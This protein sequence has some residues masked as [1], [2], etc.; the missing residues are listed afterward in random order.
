M[1]RPAE[2]QIPIQNGIMFGSNPRALSHD[3]ESPL[4]YYNT[5]W[6]VNDAALYIIIILYCLTNYDKGKMCTYLAQ[7]NF[8]LKYFQSAI[9]EIHR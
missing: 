5:W 6:D 3:P 2:A 7:T 8:M 9:D 1:S 4:D